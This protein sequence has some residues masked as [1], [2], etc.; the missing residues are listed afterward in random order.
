[1]E[2]EYYIHMWYTRFSK[3]LPLL[4]GLTQKV[5]CWE[6][7][8]VIEMKAWYVKFILKY[9]FKQLCI[10]VNKYHHRIFILAF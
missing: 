3:W 10:K 6:T 4:S 9:A 7:G 1:M 5:S 2:W 8:A